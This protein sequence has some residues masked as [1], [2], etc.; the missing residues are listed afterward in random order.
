M[1]KRSMNLDRIPGAVRPPGRPGIALVA[2]MFGLLWLLAACT[3]KQEEVRQEGPRSVQIAQVQVWEDSA[4]REFFG[5]VEQSGIS[6]LAFE[7]S[8]RVVEIAVRDGAA[9][10]KGDLI[11]RLDPEPYELQARRAEIHHRQLAADL[12]RKRK[13]RD[14]RILAQGAFEQLEA[15]VAMAKVQLDFARRDLRNTRLVAPFDGRITMRNAELQQTVQVGAPAFR[16]E[17][18]KRLDVSVDLPQSLAQ[19]LNLNS[20]L[21][22][23]AWLP[24]RTDLQFPLVYREHATQSGPASGVYRLTFSGERPQGV[25]VLPGMAVRVRVAPPQEQ[26]ATAASF[27]VPAA[28]LSVRDDGRHQVWLQ[29]AD[30]KVRSVPIT[31]QELRREQAK[32][33]GELQVGDRVVAAGSKALVE[34]Q[35]VTGMGER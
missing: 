30:G 12:V 29:A 21:H 34:G 5:R 18:L 22:A 3:N 15:A 10:K 23:L 17:N 4:V 27:A 16:L 1:M 32:V 9:V 26:A 14:E 33:Q 28:S 8:G 7:V 6:P 19:N 25:S 13:L 20:S 2:T 31:V 35:Q 24:E 11:A